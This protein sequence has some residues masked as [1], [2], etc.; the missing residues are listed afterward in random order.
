MTILGA[1]I[2]FFF[3]IWTG[4]AIVVFATSGSFYGF[5]QNMA[6]IGVIVGYVILLAVYGVYK[7]VER[8]YER[9]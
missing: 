2:G 5:L 8:E 1:I 9:Y 6:G 4:V 7:R 3:I